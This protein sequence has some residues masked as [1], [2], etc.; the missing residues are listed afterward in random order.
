MLLY[1]TQVNVHAATEA[2]RFLDAHQSL[3]VLLSRMKACV[4]Y[5]YSIKALFKIHQ[6]SIKALLRTY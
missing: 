5:R 4:F 6:G 1:A 2:Q 3:I